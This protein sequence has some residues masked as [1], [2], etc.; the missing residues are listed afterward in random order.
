MGNETRDVTSR[1]TTRRD[2]AWRDTTR[3]D[4][5]RNDTTRH[6]CGK[7]KHEINGAQ[8]SV[9]CRPQY[10]L[11]G[12][13]INAN[14]GG[15]L[16]NLTLN[17]R[18]QSYLGLTRSTSWLLMS[19]L[20]T[21]SGHQQPWYLL[22]KICTS[23]SNLRKDFSTWVIYMTSNDIKCEYMFMFPLQFFST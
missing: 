13:S 7:Y 21:S 17:V 14:M 1:D 9:A 12:I 3:R 6:E 11:H 8:S 23:W 19:W 2:V 15:L 22:C 5:T 4:T 18:G 16:E 10:L 20:F